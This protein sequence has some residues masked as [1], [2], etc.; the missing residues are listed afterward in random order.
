MPLEKEAL[1]KTKIGL[2]FRP[3]PPTFT[4]LTYFAHIFG[5]GYARRLLL[6]YLWTENAAPRCLTIGL[7]HMADLLG[8][9]TVQRLREYS[10]PRNT[11]AQEIVQGM[12]RKRSKN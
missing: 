5:S 3:V 4:D 1:H 2:W 8:G 10:F 9:K 7:K 6:P 12:E 11:F